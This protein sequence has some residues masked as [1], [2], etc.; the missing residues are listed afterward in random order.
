M[1]RPFLYWCGAL[2]LMLTLLAGCGQAPTPQPRRLTGERLIRAIYRDGTATMV[3]S[4]PA[5]AG[6]L[7]AGVRNDDCHAAMLIDTA[8]G[9]ARALSAVEVASRSRTMQLAG[10]VEGACPRP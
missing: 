3:V 1:F 2:A 7:H 9:T 8:T 4:Y 5:S 6:P 10:A